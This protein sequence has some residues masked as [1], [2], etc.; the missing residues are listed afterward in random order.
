VAGPSPIGEQ[1]E[2]LD[3]SAQAIRSAAVARI[4]GFTP[5]WRILDVPD[6]PDELRRTDSGVALVRLFGTLAEPVLRRANRL[7]EK[8]VVE[9]L[10]IA[11]VEGR[12]A[13]A[14]Q[15]LLQF[16]V[17]PAAGGSVPVPAGFQ[18]GAA[19]ATNQPDQVIFETDREVVATPSTLTAVAV[20]QNG[21][22]TGVD[23][24]SVPF[25]PFGAPPAAGNALWVGVSV[26]PG[27]ASLSPSLG[28][29]VIAAPPAGSPPPAD[30]G[31][32]GSLGLPPPPLLAWEILDGDQRL[33]PATLTRDETAGLQRTGIVEINVPD[34][35]SPAQPPAPAL[36]MA[37]WLRIRYL[38][39][40]YPAVPQL[41]DLKINVVRAT[42]VRTIR[43]EVLQRLPDDP[44]GRA[45]LAL[46]QVPVV[47]GSVELV[48]SGD[49]A[50]SLFGV[51]QAAASPPAWREVDSLAAYGPTDRVFT[52]DSQPG[53]LTFGD[54][55]HGLR[56]PEG[57][58]NVSASAY[59]AGGGAA[60]A[61]GAGAITNMLSSIKFVSAVTNPYPATGGTDA[62]QE[63]QT[64][65]R[66]GNDLQAGGRAV[67]PTDYDVLALRASGA[68]V[69]RAHAIAGLHP[70]Y[71]GRRIPGVVGVF[72]VPPADAAHTTNG[73]PT[74]ADEELQAV[75]DFLSTQ[76]APAGID[77]VAAAP[78]YHTVSITAWLVL[79]PAKDQADTLQAAGKALD[80]YL[81]PIS[82][83]DAKR[84]WPFGG[85]L[86]HTVLVRQLVE[87]PGVTAV[88]QLAIVFDGLR[89]PPC[90]D[91][92]TRPDALIFPARHELLPVL[93]GGTP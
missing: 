56:L 17:A 37:L 55:A 71:P 14:A 74:P 24:G 58:R 51:G 38:Q 72:V 63:Q 6:P 52:L 32:T 16:T 90:T 89:L 35:W 68:N 59:Q 88:P 48:V 77:V 39:G 31:G 28:L 61:V 83:G 10:R 36:P 44:D 18:V 7:P 9:Y 29:G 53:V 66:G 76:A 45:Q 93:E 92:P 11:D 12:P 4:T 85:T 70:A 20:E 69:A 34:S 19:P 30:S 33:V 86:V 5:D 13:T 22:I 79:D 60:G 65:L 54:N 75:A 40:S 27:V 43:G 82:G 73:P 25:A 49:N 80:A 64:V 46:S 1:P 42:A 50:D 21:A 62:D 87:V 81:D 57:F 67:A 84:G 78:H 15:A 2:L 47:P 91:Q 26:L 8:A 3:A 23:L 41:T